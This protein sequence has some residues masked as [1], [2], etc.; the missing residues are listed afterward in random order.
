MRRQSLCLCISLV[1]TLASGC[2]ESREESAISGFLVRPYELSPEKLQIDFD[3][4]GSIDKIIVAG[5]RGSPTELAEIAPLVRPWEFD[6]NIDTRDLGYGSRNNFYIVLSKTKNGYVVSDANPIS[7]LDTEAA[8][9]LFAVE[10]S[11]LAEMGLDELSGKAKGDVL[12]IPTEAGIDTYL[13]WNG[14][15]FSSFEPLEIP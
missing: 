9:E 7:I 10:H 3:G 6:K 14:H 13:Y 2:A 5:L 12:G 8:Q 1:L 15:T 11:A 4:D